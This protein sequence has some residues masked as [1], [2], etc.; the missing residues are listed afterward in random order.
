MYLVLTAM[1]ALNVSKKILNGYLSVDESLVK[2]K[3][4]LQD[5]NLRVSEAFK[6]SIPG[7]NRAQPYYEQVLIAQKDIQEMYKYIDE[8]KGNMVRGVLGYKDDVKVLGDTINLRNYPTKDKIDNYD[9]P[10]TI[11][12]GSNEHSPKT[13][14]LSAAELKGKMLALHDKLIAQLEKMQK[15]EGLHLLKEDYDNLMKKIAFLKPT[16]SGIIVEGVKYNWFLDNF[17]ELPM[18]AIVVNFNKMQLDLKNVEAEILQVF[19]SASGKLAIKPDRLMAQAIAP[20]AY[21]SSGSPYS[22]NIYLSAAFTKLGQGDMEVMLNVDS[23]EA[24]KG[25]KG[26]PVPVVGGIGKYT[27]NTG[28]VGDQ[29][30]HGVIKFKKPDGT[31][32]YYPFEAEYKVAKSAVAVSADMMNVFYA[33]VENPVSAGVAGRSPSDVV[34]SASGAGAKYVQKGDG[35]YIFTFTGTGDCFITVSAKEKD[36]IKPQGAPVKFRV[37][38]LPK[39]DLKIA[40]I[41]GPSELKKEVLGTVR[42]LGAGAVG[43]DFQ[44]NYRVISWEISGTNNKGR[45]FPGIAGTGSNLSPEALSLLNAPQV[46]TKIFFDAKIQGPDGKVNP[47]SQGVKV[48]R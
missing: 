35:K 48:L 25:A 23:A 7:N 20:S 33:G 26:T 14:H 31:Y 40:G 9:L 24:A 15:T 13:D 3:K 28:A 8:V 38:P 47:V 22:A 42:A 10:T 29:K 19:S 37:K 30:Y 36:G 34:I 12:I 44:A 6:S 4:N 46:N 41:F 1:L 32:D 5:N 2:S 11:L 43:F 45:Y 21:I 17:F 39:P 27:T 18:A 16:D